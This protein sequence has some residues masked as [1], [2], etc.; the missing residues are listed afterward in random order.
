[1]SVVGTVEST[2]SR[3][4]T[5]GRSIVTDS[6]IR[7]DDG[8]TVTIRQLGGKVGELRMWVSHVPSVEPAIGARIE[9]TVRAPVGVADRPLPVLELFAARDADGARTFVPTRTNTSATPLRWGSREITVTFDADGVSHLAGDRE[10]VILSAVLDT[11][12]SVAESCGGLTL[13][14]AARIDSEVGLDDRNVFLFREDRWCRPDDEVGEVCYS[15]NAAAITTVFFIDNPDNSRDGVIVEAD[16]EVNAV[17]FA[18][19]DNGTTESD[20]SCLSDLANTMT[21]EVGHLL[22]LDHTC[23][24][25]G[26]ATDGEG[27]P[28]PRCGPN[29]DQEILATTMF[30]SQTCG[31]TIKSTPE[32][33]DIAGVCNMLALADE[34][35][36]VG[37]SGGCGCG[38]SGN[39]PSP[40]ALLVAF[41]ALAMVRRRR[42]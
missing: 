34:S 6:V 13:V 8:Q 22:G 30:P 4:S 31:E 28:A 5:D 18:T 26:S 33:D 37:D 25:N 11:W 24:D 23:V 15:P 39:A 27:N 17:D 3:W 7:T 21:H 40:G 42:R 19:S 36:P 38:T 1:M 12:E 29:L 20:Q 9:A 32:A 41:G 2:N 16:I 10:F 35:S 14:E